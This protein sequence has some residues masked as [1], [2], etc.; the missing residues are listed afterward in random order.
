MKFFLKLLLVVLFGFGA[1]SS[2]AQVKIGDSATTID[3]RSIL[4]LESTS[5]ALFLPRLTTSERDTQSGWKAGMFIYNSTDSCVQFFDG[6]IW[7]CLTSTST[8]LVD[9]DSTNELQ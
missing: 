7:D 1:S 9:T 2:F 5:K 3:A 4:E 6:V 8:V